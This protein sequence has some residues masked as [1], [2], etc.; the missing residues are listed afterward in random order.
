MPFYVKAVAA[1][2]GLIALIPG[3]VSWAGEPVRL[4]ID[5]ALAEE[6]PAVMRFL[7]ANGYRQVGVLGFRVRAG[8]AARTEAF[9][10]LNRSLA[11]RLEVALVLA[12]N[13][14]DPVG[15][16]RVDGIA[17][18]DPAEIAAL[19]TRRFPMAWGTEQVQ[20][21][22]LLTGEVR[23][24]DDL[25]GITIVIEAFDAHGGP[26][27]EVVR[28]TAVADA[29]ALAEAGEGFLTRGVTSNRKIQLKNDPTPAVATPGG[30]SEELAKNALRV[31]NGRDDHPLRDPEA[32]VSLKVLYDGK[33]MPFRF[34]E[35]LAYVDEPKTGQVVEFVIRRSRDDDG[36]GYGVVLALNGENTVFRETLTA[37]RCTKWVLP[38]GTEPLHVRGFQTRD[39]KAEMFRVLTDSDSKLRVKGFESRAGKIN[40]IVYRQHEGL[41]IE[42]DP[43]PIDRLARN[44]TVISRG[45]L[46]DQPPAT[47]QAMAAQ[48]RNSGPTRTRGLI[49]QGEE[50]GAPVRDLP[51]VFEEVPVMSAS[52]RYY[53]AER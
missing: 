2:L 27:R 3:E 38:P 13:L 41:P 4:T 32:P 45:I 24:A 18:H 46:P 1:V 21:D 15:I 50:V 12:E 28:F 47:L 49:V 52:I 37:G 53:K 9:G 23:L 7:L 6:A 44:E 35:G 10:L 33:V 25:G 22:L 16:V 8:N 31:K 43:P 20:A 26:P 29:P 17:T 42:G 34:S 5:R 39:G 30:A 36:K 14:Q 11:S 51:V 40:L 48:I 19:F